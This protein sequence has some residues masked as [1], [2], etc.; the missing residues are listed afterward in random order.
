MAMLP[1]EKWGIGIPCLLTNN[2]AHEGLSRTGR[3]ASEG[4]K[5][6]FYLSSDAFTEKPFSGKPGGGLLLPQARGGGMDAA[7]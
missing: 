5:W 6:V 4:T 7:V 1:G 2:Q 3:V